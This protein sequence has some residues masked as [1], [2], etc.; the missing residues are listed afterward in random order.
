[1]KS[2][3]NSKRQFQGEQMDINVQVQNTRAAEKR[4]IKCT[5]I[6]P[7][8]G[9]QYHK[10]IAFTLDLSSSM[11]GERLRLAKI[12][13]TSALISLTDQDLFCIV[14]YHKEAF[15]IH[16]FCAATQTN[17]QV[18][19]MSLDIQETRIGT[20]LYDGW[21]KAMQALQGCNG[22]LLFKQCILFTDGCAGIGP[23]T[24]SEYQEDCSKAT[25]QLI[26]TSTVGIGGCNR[27]FL[28]QLADQCG[29]KSFFASTEQALEEVF[30]RELKDNGDVLLP[31]VTL[32]LTT[33]PGMQL[34]NL[35]PQP[36]F[37]VL[38]RLHIELYSQR[39]GQ[40]NELVLL[41]SIPL[42]ESDEHWIEVL[43]V[44]HHYQPITKPIKVTLGDRDQVDP[45]VEK[46]LSHYL[47]A[48]A[49]YRIHQYRRKPSK[50][51]DALS[52][53]L[54]LLELLTDEESWSI[55]YTALCARYRQLLPGKEPDAFFD[56]CSAVLRSLDLTGLTSRVGLSESSL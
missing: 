51:R 5:T 21:K 14:G 9:N 28:R 54:E 29:G 6:A 23:R 35:G 47:L 39:K 41:S 33:S 36:S 44:D 4:Y 48:L 12:A 55:P 15:V 19:K 50:Q 43:A 25:N 26:Y 1:V 34:I 52:Q 11:R 27:L 49:E 24:I 30:L 2:F 20:N 22:E 38:D 45:M 18:A 10:A 3:S 37:F 42:T 7:R 56:D 8:E 46:F 53:L 16:P 17:K 13:L 31:K 40:L 32:R